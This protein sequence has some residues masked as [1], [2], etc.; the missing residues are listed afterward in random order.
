L[1]KLSEKKMAVIIIALFGV[2][3]AAIASVSVLRW[4]KNSKIEDQKNHEVEEIQNLQEKVKRIPD[5]EAKKRA[6]IEALDDMT[7][8]LPD[9]SDLQHDAFL[10]LLQVMATESRV[11]VKTLNVEAEKETPE[12]KFARFRYKILVEGTYPQFVN[13]LHMIETHKQF[14]KIDSFRIG[15]KQI[16]ANG[17]PESAKKEIDLTISTYTYSAAHE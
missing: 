4:G 9:K 15:N 12:K 1:A 5:L 6:A 14:L 17:W 8:I 13:F 10:R 16:G 7:K 3:L 11:E 2:A